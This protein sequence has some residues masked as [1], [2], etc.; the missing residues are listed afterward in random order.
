MRLWFL[1]TRSKCQRKKNKRTETSIFKNEKDKRTL[2]IDVN[3]QKEKIEKSDKDVTRR[4]EMLK[5]STQIQ[6]RHDGQKQREEL[7]RQDSILG[8]HIRGTIGEFEP[9]YPSF[10]QPKPDLHYN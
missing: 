3:I 7:T 8:M 9:V 5:A 1:F 10:S 4:Q 6:R 2:D